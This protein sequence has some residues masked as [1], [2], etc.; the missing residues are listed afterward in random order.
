MKHLFYLID[1]TWLFAG[2]FTYSSKTSNIFEINHLLDFKDANGNP[3]IAHYIR[4]L[5]ATSG[6]RKYTA[7]GFSFGIDEN[8]QDIYLN[9]CSNYEP[10]DK[11][12][13]FGFSR[14]AVVARAICAMLDYGILKTGEIDY[15]S[16]LWDLFCKVSYAYH[17]SKDSKDNTESIEAMKSHLAPRM[18]ETK[19]KVAFLGLFDTVV[20]GRKLTRALQHLN[21]LPGETP[22]CAESILHLISIDETRE[23]FSPQPFRRRHPE[24]LD[25]YFFEQLWLPGV[26]TD[27]GG[28]YDNRTL[29]DLSLMI[30]ID[31][32][33]YCAPEISIYTKD[34]ENRLLNE[35]NLAPR[36]HA[37]HDAF[38][39]KIFKFHSKP[40]RIQD[41]FSK[42]HPSVKELENVKVNYKSRK[43][44]EYYSSALQMKA[45][46]SKY[47][48]SQK[49]SDRIVNWIQP[50]ESF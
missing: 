10:G 3:Q 40:R 24:S 37:E 8:I 18:R 35:S 16:E 28:G 1:G 14:G 2:R 6:L 26:H 9:I 50:E 13:I 27:I 22:K 21:I 48:I 17:F 32:L 33:L 30:M 7:G 44:T 15:I 12:Y 11:I 19:P 43:T 41:D 4:G 47:F 39:W 38:W 5:G 42:I 23:F 20:G 34:I 46:Q 36:V 45:T 49:Y 29:S 31:R 25:D